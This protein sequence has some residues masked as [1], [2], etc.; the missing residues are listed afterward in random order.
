[1]N[2][3]EYDAL[4]PGDRFVMHVTGYT[5]AFDV[6]YIVT[7][8][9]LGGKSIRARQDWPGSVGVPFTYKSVAACVCLNSL[10]PQ[11]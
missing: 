5:Y 9:R 4:K 8:E 11:T 6:S 7:Q 10:P 2:R 3:A 1:M